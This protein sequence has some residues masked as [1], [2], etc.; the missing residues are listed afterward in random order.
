MGE[1]PKRTS[2]TGGKGE[3]AGNRVFSSAR[4]CG[5]SAAP[6]KIQR[7]PAGAAVRAPNPAFNAM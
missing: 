6:A 2:L 5:A 1:R 3:A 7:R 4:I